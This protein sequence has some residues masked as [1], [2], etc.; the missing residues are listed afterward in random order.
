MDLP[1]LVSV[2]SLLLS[3]LLC[4]AYLR[5]SRR[6]T[7]LADELAEARR[8]LS[9]A[10]ARVRGEVSFLACLVLWKKIRHMLPEHQ[11]AVIEAAM[12]PRLGVGKAAEVLKV[13]EEEVLRLLYDEVTRGPWLQG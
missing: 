12:F 4:V 10:T 7:R 11:E 6:V 13:P 8:E 5:S 2:I 1:L 3:A 9:G